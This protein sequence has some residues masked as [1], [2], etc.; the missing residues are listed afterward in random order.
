M[1]IRWIPVL[2]LMGAGL[3][4]SAAAER[5]EMAE[6]LE[7]KET[8]SVAA[9]VTDSMA[10]S[11]NGWGYGYDSLLRDLD[12]WRKNPLV[13]VDSI[14]AS[15]KGRAIWMVTVTD[16]S[17]SLGR[18]GEPDTRKR[19]VF[20]HARTHPAEVQAQFV[21]N[22][23]IRF[24]L[25]S[26]ETARKLRGEFIW[27]FVPMYNPDGVEEGHARLNAHLVDLE[28]NWDKGVL[29][30]EVTAL[31][32]TFESMMA[33]PNPIDVALNLHSDQ[34]NRTRFFVFHHAAG[35]S[36]AYEVLERQF[37]G[38]VQSHFPGGIENWD[39][40]RTWGNGT[41]A[42]Y[43]EGFWWL[44]HREKVLALTYEDTNGP[45]AGKYD[46][47]GRALALGSGDY[48]R[49][50]IVAAVRR[51]TSSGEARMILIP[52]GVRVPH[53]SAATRWELSDLR[54]R[55]LAKGGFNPGETLLT[56]NRLPAGAGRILSV[57][58]PGGMPSR[59]RLPNR[60]D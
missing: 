27:N 22:E 37:I 12:E 16:S 38:G 44:Q 30:P 8:E 34:I 7:T 26:G 60:F 17:D 49:D 47:T 33:G 31:K 15:V 32:S 3:L 56:W 14:G 39:F 58:G 41:Q 29:E 5:A 24:L 13:K 36:G 2:V 19:R 55:K 20:M 54:G 45:N 40:L 4:R 1:M 59:M 28:A 43:P 21:T 11:T 48:I 42:R 6:T 35:T 50:R 53:A 23:S 57:F 46:T 9:S 18:P 52:E 25:D 10:D 51:W